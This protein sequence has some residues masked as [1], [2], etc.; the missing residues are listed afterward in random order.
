MEGLEAPASSMFA[1]PQR[2]EAIRYTKEE[3]EEQRDVVEGMYPMKGMT[4]RSIVGY[5]KEDRGFI[6]T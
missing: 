2:E 5:L 6:V 3:W 1:P 4:L